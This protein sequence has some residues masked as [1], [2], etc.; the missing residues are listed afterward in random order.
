MSAGAVTATA[1]HA[2]MTREAGVTT[3]KVGT[4]IKS[5]KQNREVVLYYYFK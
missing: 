1:G 3:V 4:R 2:A 5:L